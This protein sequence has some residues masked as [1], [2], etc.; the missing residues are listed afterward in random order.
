MDIGCRLEK[1]LTR[2]E[3]WD[4]S[5]QI[6]SF[7][8]KLLLLRLDKT[9]YYRGLGKN[10]LVC[11]QIAGRTA[12]LCISEAITRYVN[13]RLETYKKRMPGRVAGRC[14]SVDGTRLISV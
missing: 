7:A 4:G 5:G 8:S 6:C 3:L 9:R 12:R 13:I 10:C 11:S 14:V 2:C 1:Q